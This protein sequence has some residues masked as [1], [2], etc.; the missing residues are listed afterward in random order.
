V[1]QTNQFLTAPGL[2]QQ[3]REPRPPFDEKSPP[4]HP[5]KQNLHT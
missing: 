1:P 3:T 2:E 5:V 4:V